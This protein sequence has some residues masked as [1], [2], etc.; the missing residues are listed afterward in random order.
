MHAPL[1]LSRYIGEV[2]LSYRFFSPA[3]SIARARA[4]ARRGS[5]QKNKQK[6]WITPSNIYLST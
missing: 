6:T 1:S 4:R 3:F 2:L 5:H